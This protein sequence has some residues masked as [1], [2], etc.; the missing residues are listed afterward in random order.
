MTLW[1]ERGGVPLL[2]VIALMVSTVVGAGV[3]AATYREQQPERTIPP[4]VIAPPTT[5][6]G[7]TIPL[8]DLAVQLAA[9][10]DRLGV[11]ERDRERIIGVVTDSG[12]GTVTMP[13]TTSTPP[14]RSTTTTTTTAPPPPSTTPPR[15]TIPDDLL[16]QFRDVLIPPAQPPPTTAPTGAP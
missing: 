10:L 16:D 1:Q 4:V 3:F 13:P 15:V 8:D 9:E 5:V 7:R 2:T 11:P 6:P 12:V 14:P